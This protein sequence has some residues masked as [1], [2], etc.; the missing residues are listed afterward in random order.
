MSHVIHISDEAFQKLEQLAA[1]S[2]AAPEALVEGF[3]YAATASTRE[4]HYYTFEEWMRHLGMS[5]DDTQEIEA[6][7]KRD[8]EPDANA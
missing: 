4:P 7:V 8:D 2:G 6:A 5:D 1:E 3:V